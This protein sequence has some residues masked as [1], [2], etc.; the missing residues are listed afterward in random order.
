MKKK[1]KIISIILVLTTAFSFLGCDFSKFQNDL[2]PP[3]NGDYWQTPEE[4]E[5]SNWDSDLTPNINITEI[6]GGYVEEEKEEIKEELKKGEANV[7]RAVYYNVAHTLTQADFV[8]TSGASFSCDEPEEIHPGILYYYDDLSLFDDGEYYSAGF[9]EIAQE[10]EKV[11]KFSDES[12][13]CI[14]DLNQATDYTFLYAYDYQNIGYDHFVYND[15][16]V[17]YY[18]E[19]DGVIRYY[20]QENIKS[21]YDLTLGSLFNYDTGTYIYDSSIFDEYKP[22]NGL[23][24]TEEDYAKLE[25]ELIKISEEQEKNGYS[26]EEFNIVYISPENVQ[27]Y[28]DSEEAD[29]FFGYDVDELTQAFGLGTALQFTE[30]G[31]KDAA[32]LSEGDGEYDWKSFLIKCGIAGGIIIVGVTV[33]SIT[34]KLPLTL[35]LIGTI[36]KTKESLTFSFIQGVG[37]L[38]IETI[39]RLLHGEDIKDAIK[40]ASHAALD[41]FA[42]T[43]MISAAFSSIAMNITKPNSSTLKL[44]DNEVSVARNRASKNAKKEQLQS[45]IDIDDLYGFNVDTD[46]KEFAHAI[47][48]GKTQLAANLGLISKEKALAMISD[49]NNGTFVTR[50]DHLWLHDGNFKNS[51]NLLKIIKI[52]PKI[53][54]TYLKY[55]FA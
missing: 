36:N 29:T 25:E 55:L 37:T 53:A 17:T 44:T 50:A 13:V 47:D 54:L 48:V 20:E 28:L 8:T 41:V 23:G 4:K 2:T 21:N 49:G 6:G 27:A 5:D 52:K 26:V 42:N 11:S 33:L 7:Y 39:Q 34:N 10:G 43:F 32:I 22:H 30:E 45:A 1:I 35:A 12:T 24:L 16:Y 31:F 15:K 51:T 9:M 19:S 14:V 18:Q 46:P 3:S 40:G 38:A